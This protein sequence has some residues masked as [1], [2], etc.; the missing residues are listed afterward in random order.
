MNLS[1]VDENKEENSKDVNTIAVVKK[2]VD[3]S[4]TQPSDTKSISFSVS[5]TVR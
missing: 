2:K 5:Q 3:L 4:M 1:T